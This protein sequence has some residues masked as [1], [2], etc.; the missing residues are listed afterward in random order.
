MKTRNV[1]LVRP[2]N[3]AY[4]EQSAHYAQKTRKL[5]ET[6][7]PGP[8]QRLSDPIEALLRRW[9]SRRIPLTERRIV[10]YERLQRT[11]DYDLRF[12]EI[13]AVE[14]AD[15]SETLE[16]E[17]AGSPKEKDPDEIRPRRLIEIKCSSNAGT[18]S[19]AGSQLRK[20]LRPIRTRWQQPVYRHAI[21]VAVVPDMMD[22][23]DEPVPLEEF[24]PSVPEA[25]HPQDLLKTY[26]SAEDLWNWGTDVGLLGDDGPI[27]VAPDLLNEAQEKAR[28]TAERRRRRKE[29]KDEGIPREQWPEELKTDQSEDVPD[30]ET[31]R[32][33]ESDAENSSSMADALKE[34]LDDKDDY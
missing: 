23:R 26:L 16:V 21:L 33:G 2:D 5:R 4:R 31:A 18:L 10:R 7:D 14:I 1:D 6:L 32:Y 27:G 11:R 12:K 25:A 29:L 22:L 9:L 19:S 3:E 28:T 8:L 20:A 34:A 30:S 13:D 15:A 24:D 17:G